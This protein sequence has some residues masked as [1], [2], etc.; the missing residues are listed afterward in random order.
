MEPIDPK[1]LSFTQAK[2]IAA[3]KERQ[4]PPRH[5]QGEKFLKGPIPWAWLAK[6]ARQSG[7]ALHVAVVIWF[8]AGIKR[9]RS[10][11]LSNTALKELGVDRFSKARALRA[12]EE[13]GLV[14]VK[15]PPGCNPVVTI[16]DVNEI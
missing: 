16:I 10:I 6:A 4:K 9:K 15:R 12:L 1:R 8:L 13:V 2:S 3:I 11:S 7:K 14:S 5:K